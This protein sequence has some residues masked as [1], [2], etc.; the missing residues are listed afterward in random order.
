MCGMR[1]SRRTRSGFVRPTSGST[2]VPDWVSPTISKSCCSS[3]R[4]MP[5]STSRWSSA[6]TTRMCRSVA[7]T[8]S[9]GARQEP[10]W[11]RPSPACRRLHAAQRA[12]TQP[13]GRTERGGHGRPAASRPT[14][15]RPGQSGFADPAAVTRTRNCRSPL[16]GILPPS[17]RRRA[18]DQTHDP[19]DEHGGCRCAVAD[20]AAALL[21]PP[22]RA[23]DMG[24]SRVSI[25]RSG[26]IAWPQVAVR[27]KPS[28]ASRRSRSREFRSGFR[29]QYVLALAQ[30]KDSKGRRQAG[31]VRGQPAGAPEQQEL[32]VGARSGGA[33]RADDEA[34]LHRPWCQALP[35]LG[36]QQAR[37]DGQGRGR[38]AWGG[39]AP[40]PLLCAVEVRAAR[41]AILGSYAFETSAYSAHRLARRRRRRRPRNAV[42]RAP[43]PGRLARVH[44]PPQ[45]GRQLPPR[46]DALGMPVK[47]VP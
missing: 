43:R 8:A 26:P 10:R 42:A 47:I 45:R 38:Q 24:A 5:S 11:A 6:I 41:V 40:R 17:R 4:R 20:T 33:H 22:V 14:L 2:C 39:D 12:S 1:T 9:R 46:R 34:P 21:S 36:R 23:A 31:M 37:A 44:S 19:A 29:P 13:A 30:V 32:Q 25:I 7:C 27:A 15:P 28:E 18:D 3:A 35:V 16:R